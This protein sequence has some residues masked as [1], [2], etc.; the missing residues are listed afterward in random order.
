MAYGV[1]RM[2]YGVWRMAYGGIA[3]RRVGVWLREGFTASATGALLEDR[4]RTRSKEG[5]IAHD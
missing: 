5:S 2:A 1:W 3:L 4:N